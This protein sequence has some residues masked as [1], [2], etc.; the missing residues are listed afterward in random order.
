MSR[1]RLAAVGALL[2]AGALIAGCSPDAAKQRHF[3]N[4][5]QFLRA[6]QHQEAILEF[7]NAVE[8]DPFWGEARSRLADAYAANGEQ[9]Q[10]YRQY[11][12]AADL[13]PDDAG[14]QVKAVTYLLF[15]GQYEDARSRIDRVL[16]KDPGNVDAQILRGNALAGLSDLD[17]AVAQINEAINLEPGRS[18]AYTN[19]AMLHVA[20]GRREEARAAFDQAVQTDPSSVSA[21]LALANFQWSV[22]DAA[23]AERSLTRAYE[24]DRESIAVN[25][26]LA[27]FYVATGRARDAEPH[28]RLAAEKSSDPAAQFAL[29]D[30]YTS[31]NRFDDARRVLAPLTAIARTAVAAETRLAG[32]TY[33]AGEVREGLRQ[34]DGVLAQEPNNAAALLMKARWML[35]EGNREEAVFHAKAAVAASPRMA[36]A[37]YIRGLAEWRSHR[38]SEAISAFTEVLRLNPRAAIAQVQ[39]S[40]L[41]LA[42]NSVDSA[43]LFAE[44]ALRNAPDSLDA[45]LALVRAWLARDDTR[46][47]QAELSTLKKRAPDAA[48]VFALDG[49]LQLMLGNTA[50]ARAAFERALAL[51]A[52]TFEALNGLTAI[53][54]LQGQA[55]RARA[56]METILAS[57]PDDPDL[58]VLAARVGIASDH[59]GQ[60]VERLR[61]AIELDPLNLESFPL[62]GRLYA[63]QGQLAAARAE[64]DAIAEREPARLAPRLMAAMIV[65]AEGG[66]EEAKTRY[67]EILKIE[68][69]A[70][71]AANNLAAIYVEQHENLDLAQQLAEGAADQFPARAEMQH[72]LGW[73]YYQR[74]QVGPAVLRLER[75]VEAAPDNPVYHYH[76]GLAYQ[77]SGERDRARRSLRRAV[78]L[79]PEFADAEQALRTLDAQGT[80]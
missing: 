55:P 33:A 39:L 54:V 27:A 14:A 44:E 50:L 30:Y 70:A 56:R 58:L 57:S 20:Q 63:D 67:A 12:R 40:R 66:I 79:D 43:V 74:N 77:K 72:T 34:L 59:T 80:S 64:F 45:R 51:D 76:L 1:A 29:A 8:R 21:W 4:G 22:G 11:V 23:D 5:E 7:R 26:A 69:R 17:G 73:I 35:A 36:A 6:G 60:A 49:S 24:L 48:G 37:H 2:F 28:L 13:L 65:H 32:L 53:D 9:E 62:L 75:S 38:T 25:R 42:R 68:P 46:R 52:N 47:A 18:E 3:D 15:A 41:H 10:A 16:E 19:L 78:T 71:L 61:R 31:S